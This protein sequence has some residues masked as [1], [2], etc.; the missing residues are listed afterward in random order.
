M[1]SGACASQYNGVRIQAETWGEELKRKGHTLSY[2]NPWEKYDWGSFDALHIFGHGTETVGLARELYA[3]N[4]RVVCS[5]IIDTENSVKA[6]TFASRLG[7]DRLRLGTTNYN[8][9]KGRSYFMRWYARSMF[10][11]EYIKSA[12]SVEKEKIDVIPLSYRMEPGE[13]GTP[14]EQ[15]C[16]HVSK[17]TDERK[18]VK[19]LMEAA[20]KYQF[21]LVLA[22]SYSNDLEFS[23]FKKMIDE[24]QNITY[25]GRVS[26]EELKALYQRAKVFA[27]PS[28]N[29]GV[30]LV[31]LEA[32]VCGCNIVITNI[33]GPKEYYGN[34]AFL[35]NPYDVDE[36]GVAVKRALVDTEQQPDLKNIIMDN[37]NLSHC[38]DM[39]VD[40][41]QKLTVNI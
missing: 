4:P 11:Y 41:Y 17:L 31:A 3:R 21:H 13:A 37:Y 34:H 27:L 5:P 39:L 6:Y 15:F 30:G 14:K 36:I 40:S 20:V 2:I 24:H 38:V 10:E 28:T 32:A 23:P 12:Y 9:W 29:E 22:G 8:M 1:P 16:F 19:R 25:L 18:N 33:G 26:D 35:V 7:I